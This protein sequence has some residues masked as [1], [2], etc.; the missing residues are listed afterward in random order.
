MAGSECKWPQYFQWSLRLCKIPAFNSE[1]QT[2]WKL[3]PE[4][5]IFA[6]SKFEYQ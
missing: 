5:F 4:F 1:F 6:V 2:G 3:P